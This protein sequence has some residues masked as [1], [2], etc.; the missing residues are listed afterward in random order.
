[1]QQIKHCIIPEP[2]EYLPYEGMFKP[3]KEIGVFCA[4]QH[5]ETYEYLK[6][7]FGGNVFAEQP[8][9]RLRIVYD[10]SYADE[11]YRLTVN[12]NGIEI[13]ASTAA[14][15][16][17]AVQTLRQICGAG[18]TG[19]VIGE[20]GY[21]RVTDKPRF[22]WRG[23]MLDEARHFFGMQKVKQTLN[24]M[25]MLKLNV[26][27]WHLSDDQ[28][29]RVALK[30]YP[31]L[32]T[33]GAVR[34]KTQVVYRGEGGVNAEYIE[35]PYGEGCCYTLEQ[36]KEI[37]AYAARLHI[38]IVPEIDMPG[39]LVSAIACYPELSCRREP[40]EV[41]TIWGVLD[42]IGCCG[43]QEIYDF[44]YDV[45]D[46][47]SEVFP[48]PYFHIGGDEVP[49]KRW[50]E[51][52]HCQARIK[53]L[54]LK[55]EDALQSY[56]NT[57]I[58]KHLALKGRH[59]IGW[60][61]VLESADISDDAVIQWWIDGSGEVKK[62]VENGNKAIISKVDFFYLDHFYCMRPLSKTYSA[63]LETM[64]IDPKCE[65]NIMGFEAPLWTEYVR[66]TDKFDLNAYPRI[67]ALAE[68]CWTQG[69]KKDFDAFLQR[70]ES[71][72]KWMDEA[73][74]KHAKRKVYEPVDCDEV[75]GHE[76]SWTVFTRDSY[77][78]L[79][80]NNEQ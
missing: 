58:Q 5:K 71:H 19:D 4:P 43:R 32:G 73:G 2:S 1:M 7:V 21:C 22:R 18:I 6:S 79:K 23:F 51:C 37:V 39:H 63:D 70:L 60:T 66:D 59:L 3:E 11:E 41:S 14:G 30:N 76:N 31:L 65:S 8:A 80:I 24:M 47:L 38:N 48:F 53:E 26:F 69:A 54:G 15:S 77:L 68:V 13:L 16:F 25:A 36:L 56:F 72:E 29:F 67:Q 44:A 52:P 75:L 46:E 49:K 42:N 35:E 45:I 20:I 62:W 57:C 33:K 17:Y 27:H 74:I 64:G 50:K 12:E 9:G 55:N 40:T 28:G 61:E 34:S 10:H 78:E